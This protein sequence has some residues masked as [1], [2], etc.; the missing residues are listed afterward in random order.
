MANNGIDWTDRFGKAP[1]EMTE[2]EWRIAASSILTDIEKRTRRVP[3]ME[4]FYRVMVFC[5]PVIVSIM[6]AL[7]LLVINHISHAG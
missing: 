7:L 1:D 3:V 5:T 2:S 4:A 6:V